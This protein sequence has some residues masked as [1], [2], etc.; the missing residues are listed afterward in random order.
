LI[1]VLLVLA[2]WLW[3]AAAAAADD[4]AALR[5][6]ADAAR[7][8]LAERIEPPVAQLPL[9]CTAERTETAPLREYFLRQQA[10]AIEALLASASTPAAT[11]RMRRMLDK[12]RRD[13]YS[14]EAVEHLVDV[15]PGG[16][17]GL[18]LAASVGE[19]PAALHQ[20]L[21]PG[22]RCGSTY[23]GMLG[24]T[25]LPLCAVAAADY[26]RLAELKP[27]D[28]WH[29]L[30]QAWLA[31]V[32]GEPALQHALS[33]ARSRSGAGPMR[34]QIF[35]QQQLAWLR[36]E[37]GRADEAVEAAQAALR[38]AEINLCAAPAATSRGRRSSRRCATP[39]KAEAPWP[40][41]FRTPGRKAPPS[42]S[43][44]RWLR[45]SGA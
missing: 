20:R 6:L 11:Q 28:P 37:Q 36:V 44:W 7:V 27:G 40:S 33:V 43:C 30:V 41:C 16:A 23:F 22:G 5:V 38:M 39:R 14:R 35:A 19:L 32:E 12:L 10:E 17:A 42:R 25:F 31:G 9:L 34:V 15:A 2:P 13:G 26:R 1:T 8:T 24:R 21:R 3:S 4:A 45:S 29:P 18:R